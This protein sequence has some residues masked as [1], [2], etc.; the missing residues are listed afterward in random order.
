MRSGNSFSDRVYRILDSDAAWWPTPDLK[1]EPYEEFTARHSIQML[2]DGR[3]Q[4]AMLGLALVF[5]VYFAMMTVYFEWEWTQGAT[6]FIWAE[7]GTMAFNFI[8]G[9]VTLVLWNRRARRLQQEM[10]SK[11]A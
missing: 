8:M 6:Y 10:T 1:P 3:W 2:K 7:F 11:A 9:L 5:A 4:S